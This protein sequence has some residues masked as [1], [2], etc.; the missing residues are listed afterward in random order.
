M[1]NHWT[2]YL[3]EK[4]DFTEQTIW[5]N[6]LF[7]RTNVQ[8]KNK[9]NRLKKKNSGNEGINFFL[10]DWKKNNVIGCLRTM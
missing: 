7:Y 3:A 8:L 10:T 4:N 5:V 9:Q 1:I 6:K 2:N